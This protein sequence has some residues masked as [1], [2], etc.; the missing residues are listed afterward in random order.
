MVAGSGVSEP[1][2]K[3]ILSN[4]IFNV[5]MESPWWGTTSQNVPDK[6]LLVQT[7][8]GSANV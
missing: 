3:I 5:E 1:F 7:R 2:F 8:I 6:E 4:T